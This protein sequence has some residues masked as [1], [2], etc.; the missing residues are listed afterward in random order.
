M[1]Q[2]KRNDKTTQK[3]VEQMGL[4]LPK[5]TSIAGN[6]FTLAIFYWGRGKN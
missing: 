3:Q 4:I 1:K 6:A 2:E 5:L